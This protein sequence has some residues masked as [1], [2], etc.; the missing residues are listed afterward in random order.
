MFVPNTLMSVRQIHCDMNQIADSA[1]MFKELACQHANNVLRATITYVIIGRIR[2]HMQCLVRRWHKD[3][4]R[5][6]WM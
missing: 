2:F 6:T 5:L 3:A 4:R 1:I